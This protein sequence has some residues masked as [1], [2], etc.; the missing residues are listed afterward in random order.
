MTIR[1]GRWLVAVCLGALLLRGALALFAEHPGV[2]DPNHYYNLGRQL[3][4]GRGFE[5]GYV[6]HYYNPPETITHPD[7]FWMPLAGVLAAGGMA[8]FGETVQGALVPFILLGALLPLAVYAAARQFGCG[9][10][11]ALYAA[12]FGAVLPEFVM[13]SVRTDT[14]IPNA[15]FV[16]LAIVLLVEGLRR[17]G[18]RAYAASGLFAGLAY[19]TRGDN[20]LLIPMVL[21]TLAVYALAARRGLIDL[22]RRWWAGALLALVVAGAVAAPWIARNLN[23]TGSALTP[24]LSRAFFLT[25]FRDHYA[26]GRDLTWD[27]LRASQTWGQIIGKRLFELA[28][29]A[30]LMYTT[31]DL[32]LPV[33]IGGGL[34][35][36]IARRSAARLLAL[37]PALIL[38]GGSLVFYTVLS[39]YGSQGGS[40][41]KAYLS[42][43]PLLLPVGAYAFEQAIPRLAY[44]RAAVLLTL[45]FMTANAVELTRADIR[46]NTAYLRE[47]EKVRDAAL[48]LPD[49]NG[50]GEI[51]LMAQDPF[52]LRFLGLRSV[53][54]PMEDRATVLE[55]ARRYGADYL[56]MPPARPSL[57]PLYS[58]EETDPR[59]VLAAEVPGTAIELYGFD[60]DAPASEA[61]AP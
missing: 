47:M 48:A 40:F 23:A 6:W 12:G 58:G 4:A 25:D 38:L 54:I 33:A 37:A 30:K 46:F 29:S 14:L 22:P 45:A 41:K 19:L 26:Y 13:N 51:I 17:C 16:T 53:M 55:V 18:W 36:L 39:P 31:L 61:G 10:E 24:N 20:L 7:D 49:A 50:D 28:A 43:V 1:A 60:F 42:L 57:D 27:T 8:V 44:R 56:M 52:M 9:A 21:V 5:T 15:V 3:L 32:A 2:A 11:C 59:F 35:L 34:L